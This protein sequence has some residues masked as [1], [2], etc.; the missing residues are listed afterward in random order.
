M[1]QQVVNMTGYF[2]FLSELHFS[3]TPFF[4]CASIL[5]PLELACL[6]AVNSSVL[7]E[8]NTVISAAAFFGTFAFV[9][10][11]DGE[12]IRESPGRQLSAGAVNGVRLAGCVSIFWDYWADVF[13]YCHPELLW[14]YRPY[15]GTPL[16]SNELL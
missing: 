7:E 16:I 8:A 6:R 12:F 11:V 3:L 4:R 13:C 1:F 15:V 9:P 5:V 2:L 10:V 14:K